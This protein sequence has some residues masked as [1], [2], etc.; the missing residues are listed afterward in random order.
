MKPFGYLRAET[1]DGALTQISQ[2]D[3]VRPIAGGTNLLDLMKL[4]ITTPS[5]L[6]DINR[7]PLDQIEVTPDGR[8]LLGALARNAHTAAHPIVRDQY[9]LLAAAMLAAAS[10]QI[11]NMATNGGNLLQRTRCVYFYD[12]AS[13][14]NKRRPGSGCQAIGGVNRQHAILGASDHCIATHPSDMCVALAALDASVHVR[15]THGRRTIAFDDF[16][17]LPG[18]HPQDDTTLQPDE[19]ITQIEL[20]P[21]QQFVRNAAYLKIRER[22][23]YAFAMVSVAALVSLRSDGTIDEARVALGGVAHKPWR[24]RELEP[25]LVGSTPSETSFAAF[26]DAL[27]DGAVGQGGNNFKIPMAHRA[28]GRALQMA[29]DGVLSNTG[30]LGLPAIEE[31]ERS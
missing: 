26:A 16:H 25:M 22:A 14:C 2:P 5:T 20:P 13:A 12:E 8:V 19:L 7:L 21:A 30:L 1:I 15:S 3:G 31:G 11:R 24:R 6:V 9:P 27:L 28:V 18:D 17:R 4:Q 10:P 29:V 23:S